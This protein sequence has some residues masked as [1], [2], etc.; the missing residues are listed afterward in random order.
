[1]TVHI[2]RL[3]SKLIQGITES[4]DSSVTNQSILAAFNVSLKLWIFVHTWAFFKYTSSRLIKTFWNLRNT[5]HSTINSVGTLPVNVP[6]IITQIA[7]RDHCNFLDFP[8]F[9]ILQLQHQVLYYKEGKSVRRHGVHIILQI[10]SFRF[11][12]SLMISIAT[13]CTHKTHR[14]NVIKITLHRSVSSE[15]KILNR[16]RP[17]MAYIWKDDYDI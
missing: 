9:G 6:I 3:I 17:W 2:T 7:Q 11:L 1:M 12:L 16:N 10:N 8:H 13:C 5:N 4:W 14:S 15:D